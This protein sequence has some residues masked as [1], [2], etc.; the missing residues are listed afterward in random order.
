MYV[1][2]YLS[3]IVHQT[4]QNNFYRLLVN[5]KLSIYFSFLQT[6]LLDIKFMYRNELLYF[7][8]F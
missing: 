4:M 6:N 1:F 2:R 5:K 8:A 7:K 3:F